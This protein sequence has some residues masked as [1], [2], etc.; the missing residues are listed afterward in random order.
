MN[1]RRFTIGTRRSRLALRQTYI[2][3]DLLTAAHPELD[4]EICCYDASGDTML[5]V[6]APQL[7][8]DAFT[9]SVERALVAGEIDAAVHSYKDL[10]IDATPGLVVAAVP[11]RADVREALVCARALKL[12]QLLP[13]SVVGTSSERRAAAVLSLRADLHVRPIRGT[14]DARVAKVLAGE[15]DAALLALAGL[16]RLGLRDYVTEIFDVATMPPAAGQGAL[17]VQCRADDSFAL[18]LLG[19]IDN[20]ALHNAVDAELKSPIRTIPT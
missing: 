10:P 6:P 7:A 5:D 11:V 13:G 17:A 4:L 20:V 12:S 2:V 9:D 8:P 15:Y 18:D 16:D 3:V 19:D 14:V 1:R